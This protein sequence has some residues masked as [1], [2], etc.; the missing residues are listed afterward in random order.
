MEPQ[1]LQ[2]GKTQYGTESYAEEHVF[3]RQRCELGQFA[4]TG[5]QI[6][7]L[8]QGE[9]VGVESQVPAPADY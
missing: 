2:P 9:L 8:I 7:S 3:N 5:W 6:V 4:E 1:A